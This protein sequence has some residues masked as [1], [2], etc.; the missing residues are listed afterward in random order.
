MHL[1]ESRAEIINVFQSRRPRRS[2]LLAAVSH[3]E[4][5]FHKE[6]QNMVREGRKVF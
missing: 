1:V 3:L 2:C 4:E 5:A 6:D